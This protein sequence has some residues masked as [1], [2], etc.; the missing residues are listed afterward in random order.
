MK[1]RKT[2]LSYILVIGIVLIVN[3]IDKVEFFKPVKYYIAVIWFPIIIWE[4]IEKINYRNGKE[5]NILRIRT[6]NDDYN[7]VF[8]F[9]FGTILIITGYFALNNDESEKILLYSI[10]ITGI[11]YFFSGFMFVPTGIIEYKKQ[12]LS[13][14]NGNNKHTIEIDKIDS[15]ELKSSDIIVTDINQKAHYVHFMNL[16]ESDY[17][18]ISEF[19]NNRIGNKIEIKNYPQQSTVV[20]SK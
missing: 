9:I 16:I 3:F 2:Y 1:K 13:F 6:N 15:I 8:P 4:I 11:L 5:P 10:I 12:K 14:A 17:Q 20:K 19:L 7:R 18:K